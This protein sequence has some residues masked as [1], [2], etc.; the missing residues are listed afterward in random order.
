[1]DE[2][3]Y[4]QISG[5]QH[6]AFCRRQWALIHIEQAWEENLR[7]VEGK[8]LHERAHDP[9]FSEKRGDTLVT[10]E[11]PIQSHKMGVSGRCDIVEF[12]A[13]AQGVALF[14]R[15]GLWSPCPVEYKRGSP[16]TNDADRLQLCAQAL[17]L[18]EMLLCPTI[19]TAYLYYGETRR[20]EKVPLTD[21]LR[22]SVRSSF[23]EMHQY[24]DRRYTPRVKR[25]KSCNACSLKDICLPRLPQSDSVRGYMDR[26]LDGAV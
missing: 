8:I 14:G 6:F 20:R 24:Y 22:E 3:A 19:D 10:R 15:A 17:C 26:A 12:H 2:D 23:A 1:M 4:L 16:K 5:L 9:F 13:D 21:A 7:T 11:M 18:E 25:T